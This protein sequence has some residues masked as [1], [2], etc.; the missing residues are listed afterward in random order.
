[1]RFIFPC[2]PL[3]PKEV[4]P[5][6]VDQRNAFLEAGYD[7]STISIEYLQVGESKDLSIN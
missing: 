6:F 5:T 2:D 7:I 4:D 1:M 3:D